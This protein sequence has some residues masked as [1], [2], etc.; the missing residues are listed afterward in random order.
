MHNQLKQAINTSQHCQRNWDLS[1]QIKK[2]DFDLILHAATNCSSKQ[3]RRFYKIHVVTN[4]EILEKFYMLT[5]TSPGSNLYN[6]QVLANVLLA[7]QI[8]DTSNEYKQKDALFHTQENIYRDYYMSIGIA[9]A[10]A[11]LVATQLGYKTGYCAC[12]D[13]KKVATALGL[14]ESEFE[15]VVTLGIGFPKQNKKYWESHFED[16]PNTKTYTKENIEVNYIE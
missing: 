13:P 6:T 14:A 1:Q 4:R 10:Y 3:N 15:V 8:V 5:E 7:F 16:A 9:S 2:E 11:N 12:F